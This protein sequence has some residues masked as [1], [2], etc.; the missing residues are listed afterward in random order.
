MVNSSQDVMDLYEHIQNAY[1]Y[2][3]MTDYPYPSNFLQ[4]MPGSPVN[5]SCQVY[6]DI[7]VSNGKTPS[8]KRQIQ[9]LEALKNSSDIYFNYTNQ[10]SCTNFKDTDAT[11]NLDGAGWNVLACN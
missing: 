10:T 2:M 11:G 8:L 6:K 1:L 9:M 5:V 4:P 3:A 7:T